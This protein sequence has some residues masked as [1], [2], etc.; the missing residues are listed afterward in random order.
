MANRVTPTDTTPTHHVT[1]TDGA[2]TVGFILA[3]AYGK[4]NDRAVRRFGLTRTA[5]KTSQ[6]ESKY[7]D[8]EPPYMTIVQDDWSSGRGSDTYEDDT[9]R[10]Y[11]AS[12][13]QTQ[14]SKGIILAGEA[15]YATGYRSGDQRMPGDVLMV[16]SNDVVLGNMLWWTLYG[17]AYRF[18]GTHFTAS[19]S[20]TIANAEVWLKRIGTP[21]TLTFEFCDDGRGPANVIV[22]ATLP[23]GTEITVDETI[24]FLHKFD[25][26]LAVTSA[27]SYWMKIYGAA[28]D[29]E[30]NHWEVGYSNYGESAG[31]TDPYGVGAY[32]GGTTGPWTNSAD[33]M[34]YR[35]TDAD[36]TFTARFFEYKG[37]LYYVT[38]PDDN[39]AAKL[40][41]NG[42]RGV[43]DSN[44]ANKGRLYDA[45]Q[46]GWNLTNAGRIVKLWTGPAST[47]PQNWRLIESTGNGY[48]G[49]DTNWNI[50][51]TTA[52]EYV[53]LGS[54]KFTQISG[55]G[56]TLLTAPATDV[57]VANRQIMIAQ[58]GTNPIIFHRE[59]NFQ[60]VWQTADVVAGDN[61]HTGGATADYLL[62]MRDPI[63]GNILWMARYNPSIYGNYVLNRDLVP[64]LWGQQLL[65]AVVIDPGTTAW[66]EKTITNVTSTYVDTNNVKIDVAEGFTTGLIA[67]RAL[68]STDVRY[69]NSIVFKIHSTEDLTAGA[70]SLLLDNTAEC[71]SPVFTLPLPQLEANQWKTITLDYDPFNTTGAGAIISVGLQVNS[72]P[73]KAFA[74]RMKEGIRGYKDNLPIEITYDKITGL[75]RYDD[76]ENLWVLTEG[77]IGAVVNDIYS[78]IPL[79]E[80]ESIKDASNGRAHCV[81]GVY[82]YFS[83]GESME[84]YYRQ[85]LDDIGPNRDAGLPDGRRGYIVDMVGYPG[86]RVFAALDAGDGGTSAILLWSSNG[87]HELYRAPRVGARIRKLFVQVMPSTAVADRLWFSMGADICWIPISLN[88]YYDSDFTYRH[89]GHLITAWIYGGLQDVQKHWGKLKLFIENASASSWGEADY[90]LDADQDWT[91]VPGY[92]DTSPVT[93]LD[94]TD[95]VPPT[96]NGKRIRFR[97]RLYTEDHSVTPRVRAMALSGYG[98]VP[99]KHGYSWASKLTEGDLSIDLEGDEELTLGQFN[100][101]EEALAQLDKWA[102]ELTPLQVNSAYSV[103]DGKTVI[104]DDPALQ[105]VNLLSEDG[106]EEWLCQIVANEV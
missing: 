87:W 38:H 58:G 84:R 66:N 91:A 78:P 4:R 40:Y 39:T 29:D 80:M 18:F 60:G 50:T 74:L 33:F 21:G 59:S 98:I 44:G 34:Y 15:A 28:S 97:I 72:D 92:F 51:H 103:L 9:T 64:I 3:D 104:L 32:S 65:S 47:E 70:L 79:R 7:S 20:Y 75:E 53:T 17:S 73:G 52:D 37:A 95:A 54:N 81:S 67:C 16:G 2:A 100:T 76:P 90:Q 19:A 106:V 6:G 35:L 99:I 24:S 49:V 88:P 42:Y 14:T 10:Y 57:A 41:L 48:L 22:S 26:T 8:L 45:T 13:V 11:D 101:V 71:G 27:T 36:S 12:G 61:W 85:T 102:S 23:G 93:E 82:L 5:L 31:G 30:L 105:P 43:A 83:M 63:Q 56:S 94:L 62:A 55:T 69:T 89:E 68:S 25:I 77:E 46:T 96:A 86:D 1:L